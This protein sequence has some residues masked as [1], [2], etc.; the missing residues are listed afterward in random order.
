MALTE[1]MFALA[2]KEITDINLCISYLKNEI[3]CNSEKHFYPKRFYQK[4]CY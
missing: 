1:H 2:E 4:T 3:K